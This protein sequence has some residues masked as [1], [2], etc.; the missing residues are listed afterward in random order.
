M[1]WLYFGLENGATDFAPYFPIILLSRPGTKIEIPTLVPVGPTPAQG[2]WSGSGSE[3]L[4]PGKFY[5]APE[6]NIDPGSTSAPFPNS[7]RCKICQRLGV[8]P[9]E[10]VQAPA[11]LSPAPHP[12]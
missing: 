4:P 12:R 1:F 2:E 9:R 8:R 7:S 6:Q 11:A 5:T 10:K 3:V